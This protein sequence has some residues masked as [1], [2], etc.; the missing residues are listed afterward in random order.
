M[1]PLFYIVIHISIKAI[2]NGRLKNLIFLFKIPIDTWQD[3][4]EIYEQF[5]H[6]PT[7]SFSSSLLDCWTLRNKVVWFFENI[8]TT[9]PMRQQYIPEGLIIQQLFMFMNILTFISDRSYCICL[10]CAA[11]ADTQRHIKKHNMTI[12]QWTIWSFTVHYQPTC[13]GK[14]TTFIETC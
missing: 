4:F 11:E 8:L 3:F 14:Q 10:I 9:S 12:N 5:G 6:A 7:K 1:R 13:W 2:L